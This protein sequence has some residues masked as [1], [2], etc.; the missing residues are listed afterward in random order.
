MD[1]SAG[2]DGGG[3]K[4]WRACGTCPARKRNVVMDN[5]RVKGPILSLAGVNTKSGDTATL[6]NIQVDGKV[7]F[8]CQRYCDAGSC[9]AGEYKANQNG[10]GAQ[11][12]YTT[13]NVKKI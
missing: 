10:D 1:N 5:I 12:K 11:C 3:S 2:S 6:T 9:K 13:A 4:L 7:T 8:I